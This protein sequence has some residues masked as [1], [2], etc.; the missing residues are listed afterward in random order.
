MEKQYVILDSNKKPLHEFKNGSKSWDEVKDFNNVGMLIPS[1]FIVLD[2]DSVSESKTILEI[3]E[4][5]DIKCKVMK[6]TR[7]V[8]VWFKSGEPWKNFVKTRLA[9]DLLA[10]CR[11]Y[12]K[13]GYVKIKDNGELREWIRDCSDDEVE[14]VP[15]W[16]FPVTGTG[17]NFSFKGMKSGDGRNQELF[18]Y[19]IFLQVKGFSKEE[20]RQTIKIINS[21]VFAESI[22]AS[23]LKTILRD[24][25]FKDD[26]EVKQ[27]QNVKPVHNL[28][29]EE[30]LEEYNIITVNNVLYWYA[31]GYYKPSQID[32][33]REMITRYPDIKQQLR[34][35]VLEYLKLKTFTKREDIKINPYVIN[36]KNCRLNISTG[37]ALDYSAEN[38]DFERLPVE[39]NHGAYCSDVD[40]LLNKV[41]CGDSECIEL[42]EEILG[43][44]LL[45]KNIYQKAFL[46]YGG[47]SNGKST[48]LKLIRKLIGNDNV[49]T[50]GLDQLVKDFQCAEL[51]NK[52]VNI[53]D[54]I[55]YKPIKDSGTLKKLFSGEPLTVSRKF[56]QPFTLEPYATHLFS[57]NEIPRNSDRS[58]GMARRWC[59][60]P[61]NATFSKSDVDYDPLIF[62][63]VSTDEALSYLLNRAIKGF[64]RLQARGYY[65]EP[66]V[67]KEAMRA[68]AISNNSV[69]SWLED[70][71]LAVEYILET[72]RDTLYKL[73]VQWCNE[74]R[75]KEAVGS[76]T[77]YKEIIKEFGLDT[78]VKQKADGKRY[79][80]VKLDF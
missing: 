21:H 6:T 8:H 61:F 50:I 27:L 2:F 59:F 56:A 33:E 52:L 31:D 38:I 48:I 19:I 71:S 37:K 4:A 20:I 60:V 66:K 39:Y 17:K 72:P 30:L 1:P 24:E 77:F 10:D 74:S 29:A 64:K 41:F 34:R 32:L 78:S 44:C 58:D 65:I 22:G 42:F 53:G 49:S 23:E 12:G 9:I 25:S 57:C 80:T 70:E 76:K 26:I 68:Y 43:D 79:F 28:I 55:N 63:K 45:R 54:D 3:I 7:G 69:L 40:K 73:Y 11:S 5:L 75:I 67:V 36:L 18:N 14:H 15:K 46:F 47:G 13:S 62:E 35:E 16:L 51:E